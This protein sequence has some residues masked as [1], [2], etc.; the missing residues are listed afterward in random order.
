MAIRRSRGPASDAIAHLTPGYRE[1]KTEGDEGTQERAIER[2]KRRRD[3]SNFGMNLGWLR[4]DDDKLQC[5]LGFVQTSKRV[6]RGIRVRS[7]G[8]G[9]I[10]YVSE[11][12]CGNAG[13]EMDARQ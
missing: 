8:T 10:K 3:R 11:E 12:S 2:E 5:V 13:R 1:Q 7:H 4:D 9:V 6:S